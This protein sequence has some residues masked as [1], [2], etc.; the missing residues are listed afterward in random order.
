GD[1][2]IRLTQLV[3]NLFRLESFSAHRLSSLIQT[4]ILIQNPDRVQGE[5]STMPMPIVA[6]TWMTCRR[7]AL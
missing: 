6:S 3:D 7:S 2:H 1:Q 5:R 4:R